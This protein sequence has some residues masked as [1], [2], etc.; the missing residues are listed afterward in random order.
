V[1][2]ESYPRCK[3]CLYWNQHR[4][5]SFLQGWC[6]QAENDMLRGRLT[7]PTTTAY[8]YSAGSEMADLLTEDTHGCILHSD[9]N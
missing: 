9:L 1:N 3:T 4:A 5:P 8:A 6:R 2:K 7:H